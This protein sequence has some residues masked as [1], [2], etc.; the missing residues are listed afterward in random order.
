MAFQEVKSGD[1][2][3]I[4]KPKKEGDQVIGTVT[5]KDTVNTVNG[6]SDV[7]EIED[8]ELGAVSVFISAGLKALYG[9]CSVGDLVRIEYEGDRINEKTSRMFHSFKTAID[10]GT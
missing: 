4:W 5:R 6:E 8:K 2:P 1:F 3:P 9:K 7:L 10:D